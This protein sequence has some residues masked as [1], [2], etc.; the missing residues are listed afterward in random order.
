M[1]KAS[2]ESLNPTKKNRKSPNLHHTCATYSELPY[3][4]GITGYCSHL[5][6]LYVISVGQTFIRGPEAGYPWC[7]GG[8]VLDELEVPLPANVCARFDSL[9]TFLLTQ[10][11]NT[12]EVYA[13]KYKLEKNTF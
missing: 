6:I 1:L 11:Q 13:V 4:I 3:Y 5:N 8:S 12:V 9:G 7:T 2:K 10:V